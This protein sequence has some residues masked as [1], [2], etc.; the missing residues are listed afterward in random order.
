MVFCQT[1]PPRSDLKSYLYETLAT[2]GANW[3]AEN[4]TKLPTPVSQDDEKATYTTK[5]ALV[6]EKKDNMVYKHKQHCH[7]AEV[8]EIVFSHIE[9]CIVICEKVDGVDEVSKLQN[10]I[11]FKTPS[12]SKLHKLNILHQLN[13][14]RKCLW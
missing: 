7:P 9:L 14:Q 6:I 5:D 2:S 12:T 8:I 10:S 11:N 4:I 3:L 1:Y 13:Y